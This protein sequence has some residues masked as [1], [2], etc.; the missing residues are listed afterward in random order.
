M[1]KIERPDFDYYAA[2]HEEHQALDHWFDKHIEPI[3][4]ALD[5][6]VEVYQRPRLN[7]QPHE[8]CWTSDR[9]K[10]D[11]HKALLISIE[12]IVKE[13]FVAVLEEIA[14]YGV[15]VDRTERAKKALSREE[16]ETWLA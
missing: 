14:C 15:T 2:L 1:N 12:P 7:K 11:T 8:C 10:Q 4:K 5:E 13:S 6:A 3:N 9:L 16:R